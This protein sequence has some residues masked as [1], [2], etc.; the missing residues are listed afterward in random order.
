MQDDFNEQHSVTAAGTTYSDAYSILPEMERVDTEV[1]VQAIGGTSPTLDITLQFSRDKVNW[2]D[3]VS[4]TQFTATGT[5]QVKS[6]LSAPWF[7]FKVVAGGTDPTATIR[8]FALAKQTDASSADVAHGDVDSG[9]PLKIG[10][11]AADPTSLPSAVDVGDRVNAAFSQYGEFLVYLTRLIAGE[12]PSLG[13][14]NG[15]LNDRF[16][17]DIVYFAT[18]G[19]D[20]V[21][22]ADPCYLKGILVGADVSTATI[23]VSDHASDG[24]GNVEIFYTGDTLMTSLGGY[25]PVEAYF[26]TGIAADLTNQTNVGFVIQEN[27]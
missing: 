14:A 24:D 10:G 16:E 11:Y 13:G 12:N 8:M 19:A 6:T 18:A 23:E 22:S 25:I 9:N 27:A 7:R 2:T 15:V 3:D 4:L 17:G 20:K 5:Q 21:V 26:A 1:E